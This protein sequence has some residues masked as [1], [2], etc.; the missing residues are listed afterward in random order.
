MHYLSN[1]RSFSP[2][3][4]QLLSKSQKETLYVSLKQRILTLDLEPGQ[5][6]DEARVAR[7]YGLSRTPVRDVLRQLAGEGYLTIEENR[8]AYVASMSHKTLRSFFQTAPTI[9]SAVA[10]LAAQNWRPQQL[11]ALKAAQAKFREAILVSDASAMAYWNNQFHS[12]MG[13]MADNPYLSPSL[14]RL[15]IDH[16][17]IGETFYAARDSG[18]QERLEDAAR[19]HDE[20]ID[21]IEQ[22]DAERAKQ[23]AVE[24][25]ALSRDNIELYVRPDPI[26]LDVAAS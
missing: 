13:D 4:T 7:E 8:G 14:Q 26:E 24:H 1:G 20:F 10:L 3:E 5:S 22:R 23:L 2:E 25:W 17:R 15:L 6:L 21:A 9:Y 18:M 11:D 12:I 16:A 19:H